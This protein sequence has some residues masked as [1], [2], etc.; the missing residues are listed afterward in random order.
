MSQQDQLTVE[1][2]D[3]NRSLRQENQKLNKKVRQSLA[4]CMHGCHEV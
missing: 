4:A 1:L 3:Q 2:E